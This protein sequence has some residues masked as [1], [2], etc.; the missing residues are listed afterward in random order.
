MMTHLL[1]E[2]YDVEVPHWNKLEQQVLLLQSVLRAVSRLALLS[3]GLHLLS[4]R[5]NGK[6]QY[7]DVK[8][9]PARSAS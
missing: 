8:F 6:R 2:V 1:F 9:D 7:V 3:S 4:M 5:S